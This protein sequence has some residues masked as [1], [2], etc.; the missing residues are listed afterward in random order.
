MLLNKKLWKLTRYY[1]NDYAE[2]G[3]TDYSFKLI[4][5]PFDENIHPGPY[6]ILK[7]EEGKKK[8]DVSIP[9]DTTFSEWGTV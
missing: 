7:P 4:K 5:N 9:D 3:D 2:F 1:L 8:S 6:M